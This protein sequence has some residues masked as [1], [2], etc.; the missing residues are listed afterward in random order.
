VQEAVRCEQHG[1]HRQRRAHALGADLDDL[2]AEVARQAGGA[3]ALE[4]GGVLHIERSPGV[5]G[6]G[7]Q[8]SRMYC[9]VVGSKGEHREGWNDAIEPADPV[10]A[11][12]RRARRCVQMVRPPSTGSSMPVMKRPASLAR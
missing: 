8:S 5:D 2:D 10:A 6:A 12:R 1:G 3:E 7:A 4:V 11:F 9:V